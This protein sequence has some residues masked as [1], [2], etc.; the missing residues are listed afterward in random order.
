LSSGPW[1]QEFKV[2]RRLE[3]WERAAAA[4]P[5]LQPWLDSKLAEPVSEVFAFGG[6]QNTLHDFA[7][8]GEPAVLGWVPVGDSLCHTNAVFA[9]GV[10]L[11]LDNALRLAEVVRAKGTPSLERD[12]HAA[13]WPTAASRY[14]ASAE[15]DSCRSRAWRGES[16]EGPEHDRARLI[17]TVIA[18]AVLADSAVARAFLRRL[19]LLDDANAIFRNEEVLTRARAAAEAAALQGR[20]PLGPSR[21]EMLELMAIPAS[22]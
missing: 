18:P 21:S 11:A 12:Y 22:T 20:S 2:L 3:S 10:S 8:G 14:Q 17:R 9:W 15:L 7:P 5:A 4:I 13:V 1:D 16:I 6:L 19:M